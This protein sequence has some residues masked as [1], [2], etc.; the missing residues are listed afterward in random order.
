MAITI[1]QRNEL[2]GLTITMFKAAPG[3]EVL[4]D[5]VSA[6]DAGASLKGIAAILATKAEFQ[7]VYPSFLTAQEF[8]DQL[9]NYLLPASTPATDVAWSKSWIVE[10][11]AGGASRANVLVDAAQALMASTNP[12]FAD[13]QTLMNNRVDVANHYTVVRTLPSTT[14]PQLQAVL[15]LVTTDPASVTAAKDFIDGNI[16][17]TTFDLTIGVDT[18]T[19]G[20]GAD[21][22][23]AHFDALNDTLSTFSAV[24]HIDGG[25]GNDTFNI[26]MS[27]GNN[28]KFPGAATITNVETINLYS[29]D[30]TTFDTGAGNVD[31]SKFSGVTAINQ[32]STANAVVNLGAGTTAGFIGTAS[33]LSVGVADAAATAVVN[34]NVDDTSTS[35]L[36]IIASNTGKLNN[37]TI[38]GVVTDGA[39]ANTTVDLLVTNITVGKDV[40]TLTLNTAVG[41]DLTVVDTGSAPTKKVSTLD[42]TSSTGA[43]KVVGDADM[44]TITTGSGGDNVTLATAL[45]STVKTASL[46]TG[47]GNDT[48]TIS[49]AG[50]GASGYTVNVDAGTGNDKITVTNVNNVDVVVLAGAGNDTVTVAIDQL[51]GGDQIDGG[52]GYDTVKTSATSLTNTQYINLS[53]RLVNFEALELTAAAAI[54]AKAVPSTIQDFKFDVGGSVFNVLAGQTVSTGGSLFAYADGYNDG[55]NTTKV[56]GSTVG[57]DTGGTKVA[58][59]GALDITATASSTITV[60]AQSVDLLVKSG[61]NPAVPVIAVLAGDVQEASIVLS[62]AGD[63]VTVGG[64]A[65]LTTLTL[66]GAGSATVNAAATDKLTAVDASGLDGGLTYN[67]AATGAETIKLGAGVDVITLNGSSTAGPVVGGVLT[68][69]TM[70]TIE[71]FDVGNDELHLG[72]TTFGVVAVTGAT[73]VTDAI[74]IAAQSATDNAVFTYGGDAYVLVDADGGAGPNVLESTD[75]LVKLVGISDTADLTALAALIA[76]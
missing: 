57:S 6:R 61:A 70:D 3:V 28:A 42:A 43:V 58:Y 47:A 59:A 2:V 41:V 18:F 14:L 76:V 53:T 49:T 24:D 26:Y 36:D 11:L 13:A 4:A 39:D 68:F 56:G 16:I 32:I 55:D 10:Q 8:A 9:I 21:T 27:K 74:N 30:G 38:S 15:D 67:S 19:G 7:Q 5:L 23:N 75:I 20:A 12:A 48:L 60:G 44:S 17:G 64:I 65:A 45:S 51:T 34:L 73:S 62:A 33:A 35:K 40:Q 69:A 71:N 52:D 22:I 50:G 1:Q 63:D 25:K 54:N 31:A 37:V 46:T 72:V 66:S 29:L